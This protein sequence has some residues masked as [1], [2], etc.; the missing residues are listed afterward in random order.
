M[1]EGKATALRTAATKS[2]VGR[3]VELRQILLLRMI[4]QDGNDE[5]SSKRR[6]MAMFDNRSFAGNEGWVVG[7][8]VCF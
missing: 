2:A 3:M 4:G 5:V 6:G 1:T 8:E 7:S